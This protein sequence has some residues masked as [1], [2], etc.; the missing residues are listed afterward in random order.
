MKRVYV[1]GPYSADNVITVLDNIRRGQRMSTR[2]MLAGYAPFCPWI[3]FHFQLMLRG[4]EKLTV[5]DYYQYSMAWLEVSDVMLILPNYETSSG[6]IAEVNRGLEL[7]KP[8][9]FNFNDLIELEE[10]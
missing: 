8:V 3:D 4:G 6:T 1:A 10:I 7:N 2:V 9:Y 5:K